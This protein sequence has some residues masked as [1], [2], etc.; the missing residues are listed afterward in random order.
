MRR[1]RQYEATAAASDRVIRRYWNERV[2]DTRLSADPPGAPGFYTALDAYRLRKNEYLPQVV[3]FGAWAGRQ[4][5]EIGCGP[6]LDLARFAKGGALVTGVDISPVALDLAR[7]CCRAAGVPATLIEAD[8]ACL[9]FADASFDLVYCHGVLSFVRDPARVVTEAHRVLRPGGQVILMVYNRRS[10]MNLL[11]RIPGSPVGQ[12]HA[13]APS[14]RTWSPR[15]FE[16]LLAPF[17]D[18]RLVFERYAPPSLPV[19]LKRWLRPFGWHLLA[20][21]RK[22]G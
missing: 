12:G 15:Q 1:I 5:L 17:V 6:G 21:G 2:N 14:F 18:R 16:A 20:F 22:A 3:D 9:P 10:W 11:L 8:G 13:D 19:V 7:G 4:V